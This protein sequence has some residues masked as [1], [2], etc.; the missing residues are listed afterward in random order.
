[1]ELLRNCGKTAR[2]LQFCRLKCTN[3]TIWNDKSFLTHSITQN[4]RKYCKRLPF[5]SINTKVRQD[6]LLY[7]NEKRPLFVMVH[8]FGIVSCVVTIYLAEFIL[9]FYSDAPPKNPENENK[10][11]K[12]NSL[13]KN[14]YRNSVVFLDLLTGVLVLFGCYIYP[15]QNVRAIWLLKGGN[16]ATISTYGWFGKERKLTAELTDINC[17]IARKQENK[18]LLVKVKGTKFHFMINK[19]G[20]FHRPDLFDHTVGMNRKLD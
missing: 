8:I 1:M 13:W 6:V 19:E 7:K 3:N 16:R 9:K 5:E 20:Q 12:N 15:R 10:W 17:T 4:V 11:W 18:D 2:L 14:K